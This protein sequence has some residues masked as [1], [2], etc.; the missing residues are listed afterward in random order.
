[1]LFKIPYHFFS[2]SATEN[3]QD[4]IAEMLLRTGRIP[5]DLR[6]QNEWTRLLMAA[7][8][9]H[10]ELVEPLLR[11]KVDVNW[12]IRQGRGKLERPIWGDAAIVGS[13]KRARD[14]S[15]ATTQC[16]RC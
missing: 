2:T 13:T 6:Y 15:K 10:G 7:K 12:K 9:G 5:D 11:T 4:A 14:S 8:T 3:G 16:R 1:M